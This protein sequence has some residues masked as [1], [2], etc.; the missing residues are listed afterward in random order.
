MS[1]DAADT[2]AVPDEVLKTYL[3]TPEAT[4][5]DA[6]SESRSLTERR[7]V[8]ALVKD[9]R[10]LGSELRKFHVDLHEAPNLHDYL[11]DPDR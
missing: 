11:P 5:A 6:R 4:L 7:A 10:R 8:D 1:Q 9:I 3:E 2:N